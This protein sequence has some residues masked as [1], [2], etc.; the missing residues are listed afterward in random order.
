MSK[1]LCRFVYFVLFCFLVW[2]WNSVLKLSLVWAREQPA[3]KTECE[4]II[5]FFDLFTRSFKVKFNNKPK[6][7]A[8]MHFYM[9]ALML[10]GVVCTTYVIGVQLWNMAGGRSST[11]FVC[12]ID[13]CEILNW[14]YC[15]RAGVLSS[16]FS[17]LCIRPRQTVS[18]GLE[19]LF[20]AVNLV[21]SIIFMKL[22]LAQMIARD[23]PRAGCGCNPNV[24][25]SRWP[26]NREW[27][28]A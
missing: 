5:T 23:L 1:C 17:L 9:L 12:L 7:F 6:C 27:I 15:I 20:L 21:R 8:L 16:S 13:E 24:N 3:F 28:I 25:F 14:L 22:W 18:E 10:V 2:S 4:E 11:V 19:P 26:L